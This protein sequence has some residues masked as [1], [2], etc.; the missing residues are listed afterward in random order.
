MESSKLKTIIKTAAVT[1]ALTLGAEA[2]CLGRGA[3][4]A[5]KIISGMKLLNREFY[6][7]TD[8]EKMADYALAGLTLSTDD[9]Y[10]NYYPAKEFSGYL[11]NHQNDYIG[12][13]ATIG[14]A[15]DGGHLMIVSV[16]EGSPAKEHG[17]QSGDI[18]LSVDG[19][20]YSADQ[21]TEL[22][23]A[24][25]GKSDTIDQVLTIHISRNGEEMDLE[26]PRG[27]IE[28]DTI[29][30]KMLDDAIGYLRITGFDRKNDEDS[31]SQDTYEEFMIELEDL[32]KQGMERLVLDLRNNPG[33]DLEVVSKIADALLPEGVITYTE[34]K[35]G[36]RHYIR[37]DA[38]WE[39]FPMVVLVNGNSA[40]ASEVLT[41]ALKD[42]ERAEIVG[43][44]TYGKG[45]V[46]TIF[47]FIDGAGMSVTTAKYFS[48]NG[49][50]IHEKG[51]QPDIAVPL[52]SDKPIESLSLAEDSQLSRAISVLA[53][54]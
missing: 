23:N 54:K 1:V 12:I 36:R 14:A 35:R 26:I 47:P 52:L 11:S 16:N 13:G 27:R 7:G 18:L 24:L 51:I 33:G 20:E 25:K 38:E 48:P 28:K 32:K 19:T 50:C 5:L 2:L 42:Y 31:D 6:F 4:P 9:P 40:S 15:E 30:S 44:T 22:S 39:E 21:L 46:Q 45:I 49:I 43:E 10:T 37:S 29:K 8:G 41:G 53:E 34:T 17:L 3:L